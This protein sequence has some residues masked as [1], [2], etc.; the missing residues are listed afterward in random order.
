MPL[1]TTYVGLHTQRGARV[2][3]MYSMNLRTVVRNYSIH[4]KIEHYVCEDLVVQI[5]IIQQ[6]YD[7][8]TVLYIHTVITT[9]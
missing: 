1:S 3:C 2:E 6:K 4:S 9:V 5:R 8:C 7:L